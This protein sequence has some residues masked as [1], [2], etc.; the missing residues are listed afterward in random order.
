[1]VKELVMDNIN[2]IYMVLKKMNLYDQCEY[3]FDI[4]LFGLVKAANAFDKSKDCAFSTLA[5]T[6]IRNEILHHMRFN[7]KRYKVN[8]A[9]SL[10]TPIKDMEEDKVLEDVIANEFNMDEYIE[11]KEKLKVLRNAVAA[12]KPEEQKLLGYYFGGKMT[13]QEISE[14]L[15]LS[16]ATICR[17]IKHIVAKLRVIM[18]RRFYEQ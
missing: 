7:S 1:M 10:N 5:T 18:L 4:G 15:N 13:Q 14:K 17:K 9:I 6:C 8:N 3:Y 2:L 11:E 16:Q 12:L